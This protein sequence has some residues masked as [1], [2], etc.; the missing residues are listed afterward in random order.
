MSVRREVADGVATITLD[1]PDRLN[2]LTEEMLEALLAA[3]QAASTDG[4]VRCVVLAGAGRGF[5][6]GYDLS[7][8]GDPDREWRAD[9]A[10]AQMMLHAQVPMLL[11]RMPKPTIAAIRGPCAGS[12]MVL[13]AACDLRV[14]S[15]SARFKL[16]FA[17]AGRCGDPGGSYLLTQLVGPA[18]ARALFLL[19]DKIDAERALAIG[20]VTQL[21]ADEALDA[22][23]AALAGRLAQG[24]TA[25]YA[26]MK[27][28]L[29]AA[30]TCAFEEAMASEAAAN[31][32]LSL[33]HDGKEAARAFM[34]KRPPHF[35]GY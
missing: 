21:V 4:A 1:R 29:N 7:G 30:E 27:R 34:E 18:Q 12:G 10:A 2:A 23:V 5:C 8:S 14:A 35:R 16:A 6:A 26:A 13:A 28:N 33:S 17:S 31:A 3:L 20:L 9:E 19:D 25:A 11:K 24:P 32:G 22:E 15:L